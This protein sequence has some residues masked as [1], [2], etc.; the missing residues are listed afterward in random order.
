MIHSISCQFLQ[1]THY[2][3]S[4][5]VHIRTTEAAYSMSMPM[6]VLKSDFRQNTT[7]TLLPGQRRNVLHVLLITDDNFI[8]VLLICRIEGWKTYIC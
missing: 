7:Y 5:T 2:H 3:L 1:H 8:Y 4:E 6:V